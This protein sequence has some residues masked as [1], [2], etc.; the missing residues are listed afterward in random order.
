MGMDCQNMAAGRLLISEPYPIALCKAI[1]IL[2]GGAPFH[3]LQ[4]FALRKQAQ[5]DVLPLNEIGEMPLIPLG[6]RE[7]SGEQPGHWDQVPVC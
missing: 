6:N 1:V 7:S 2:A 4:L 3:L 5:G